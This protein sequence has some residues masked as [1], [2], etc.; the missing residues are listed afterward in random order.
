M[1]HNFGIGYHQVPTKTSEKLSYLAIRSRAKHRF[2]LIALSQENSFGFGIQIGHLS[3]V[4]LFAHDV[5]RCSR[6]L[7]F[8]AER[9][10]RKRGK[11]DQ[12]CLR[13][14]CQLL[15][16]N[17]KSQT[18][19]NFGTFQIQTKSQ[20]ANAISLVSTSVQGSQTAAVLG[21]PKCELSKET[22]ASP[23]ESH[24]VSSK[25]AI[26]WNDNPSFECC[27]Q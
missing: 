16:G 19:A 3:L 12:N 21:R 24:L 7:R 8:E 14:T 9:E 25:I 1:I 17:I 4:H 20:N 26:H 18:I 2:H 6:G 13:Q 23:F 15:S 22:I 27:C 5:V 10:T 11:M